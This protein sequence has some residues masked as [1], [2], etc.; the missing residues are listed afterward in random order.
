MDS[1]PAASGGPFSAM[2]IN[3]NAEQTPV[4]ADVTFGSARHRAAMSLSTPMRDPID[5]IL[6]G[7]HYREL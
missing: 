1:S 2:G 7:W 3:S 5:G 6:S 4:S